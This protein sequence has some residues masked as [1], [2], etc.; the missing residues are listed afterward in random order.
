MYYSNFPILLANNSIHIYVSHI[1]KYNLIY[2]ANQ[3]GN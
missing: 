1:M 3:E 2:T